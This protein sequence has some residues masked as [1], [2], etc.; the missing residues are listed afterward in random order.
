VGSVSGR[1]LDKFKTIGLT[2]K[3]AFMVKAPIIAECF[4]NIECRVVD[5]SL[6]KKYN[7]FILEAVKASIDPAQKNPKTLHHHG[8]GTFVADGIKRRRKFDSL[9]P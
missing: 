7:F 8:K 9:E 2:P 4:A 1:N 3:P 5:A 6:V